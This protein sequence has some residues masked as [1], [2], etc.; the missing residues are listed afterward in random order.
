MK[1]LAVIVVHGMGDTERDYDAELKKNLRDEVGEDRWQ[2]LTWHKVYYQHLLQENQK[3]YMDNSVR[4]ADIDWLPL[5]RF[6]L[7]GFSDAATMQNRPHL[8]GS[9]YHQV[10]IIIRQNIENALAAL[11]DPRKP[12]LLVSHSLGCQVMSNFIWDAQQS[13]AVAGVFSPADSDTVSKRSADGRFRRLKTLKYW[14][15]SGCNIP[16]FVAGLPE[17]EIEPVIVDQ[18]GWDFR[19]ENYYDP[20]DV[21]GWPLRPLSKAYEKAIAVDKDINAGGFIGGLTPM[22]HTQYWKDD[23]FLDPIANAIRSLL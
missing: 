11:G 2:R 14:F 6:V 5:R 19:W 18:R 1:D 7:Y 23:D 9:I 4:R 16:I 8:P 20:D 21:L 13:N 12:V 17:H 10:Q 15:T 22:S 3:R